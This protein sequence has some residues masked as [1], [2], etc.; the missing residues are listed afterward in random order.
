MWSTDWW[1]KLSRYLENIISQA[2]SHISRGLNKMWITG[3]RIWSHN[4]TFVCSLPGSLAPFVGQSIQVESEANWQEIA[5]NERLSIWIVASGPLPFSCFLPLSSMKPCSILFERFAFNPNAM[6][7]VQT[8]NLLS[9]TSVMYQQWISFYTRML[10]FTA[11]YQ[12]DSLLKTKAA[13]SSHPKTFLMWFRQMYLLSQLP[14]T[15]TVSQFIGS[16]CMNKWLFRYDLSTNAS[17]LVFWSL[18]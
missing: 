5:K 2:R 14:F 18:L 16:S 13:D 10:S 1:Y 12:I 8:T 3:R 7:Q 6:P 4:Q 17:P 9:C 11:T 15:S